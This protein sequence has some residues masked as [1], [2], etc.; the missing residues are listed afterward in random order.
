MFRPLVG[1]D[2]KRIS[3]HCSHQTGLNPVKKPLNPFLA[4]YAFATVNKSSIRNQPVLSIGDWR[5]S[6]DF[7]FYY[8]LRV[9]PDPAVYSC[10]CSHEA[11]LQEWKHFIGRISEGIFQNFIGSKLSS[12]GRNLSCCRWKS[13]SK[14][15]AH[16]IFPQHG[17][18]ALTT[19]R[20][21]IVVKLHAT[22]NEFN[23]AHNKSVYKASECTILYAVN[24]A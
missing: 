24:E 3:H 2:P 12:I 13:A 8:I 21:S 19:W 16:S 15:A 11:T 5:W 7:G 23:R 1:C 9:W 22:L 20:V 6:L 18:H 4:I 10:Y 14:Q 17:H